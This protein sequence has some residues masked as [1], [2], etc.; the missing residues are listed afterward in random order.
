MSCLGVL[1]MVIP[2]DNVR[3]FHEIIINDH[4]KVVGWVAVTFL[5]NPVTTDVATFKLDLTLNYV[6]P[7]VDTSFV[8][9]QAD[10]WDNASRL[11]LCDVGSFSSSDIPRYSLM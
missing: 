11:T 6:V 3:D 8:D 2:T 1:A 4:G 10:R 5:D 7:L 9:S